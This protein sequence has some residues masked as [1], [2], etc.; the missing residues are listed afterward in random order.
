MIPNT[1]TYSTE[2]LEPLSASVEIVWLNADKGYGLV[3]KQA[4]GK[5]EAVITRER[6]LVATL[7]PG[8]QDRCSF[9]WKRLLEFDFRCDCGLHYCSIDCQ[10]DHGKAHS[11]LCSAQVDS[12][13]HPAHKVQAACDQ[14]QPHVPYLGLGQLPWCWPTHR[15]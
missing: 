10:F 11:V 4:M 5:G 8:P 1:R 14:N 13:K 6:P 12:D 15:K 3:C 7:N 9:C 2:E